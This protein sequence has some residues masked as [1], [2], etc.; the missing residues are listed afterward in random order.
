VNWDLIAK[1][2]GLF[3]ATNFDDIVV[4]SLFFAQGAGQRGAA[5]RVVAG[6]YLA[7]A[8]RAS[9]LGAGERDRTA[10]L[11]FTRRMASGSTRASCTVSSVDRT[12]GTRCAGTSQKTVPRNV[13]GG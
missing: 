7:F 12:D 4:L 2:V 3:A 13:P 11:P 10:D 5:R 6:H 8:A 9:T 1:A